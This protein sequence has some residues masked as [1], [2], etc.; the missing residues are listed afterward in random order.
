LAGPTTLTFSVRL[1]FD[2]LFVPPLEDNILITTSLSNLNLSALFNLELNAEQLFIVPFGSLSLN[3][4]T[5]LACAL[6]AV[7][8]LSLSDTYLNFNDLYFTATCDGPCTSP[9]LQ[10]I[11]GFVYSSQPFASLGAIADYIPGIIVAI[12]DFIKTPTVQQILYG[13]ATTSDTCGVSFDLAPLVAVIN[14]PPPPDFRL[15]VL[16]AL[17]ILGIVAGFVALLPLAIPRHY[18]LKTKLLAMH[19]RQANEEP[20][21][22]PQ[23]VARY[24]AK[25]E[26]EALP[27]MFHPEVSVFTKLFVPMAAVVNIAFLGLSLLFYEAFSIS[28]FVVLFG[29]YTQLIYLVPLTIGT[30]ID[31]L[32]NSG[33]GY[34]GI[35]L[36]LLSGLWPV[37]KNCL[38]VFLLLAPKWIL[39]PEQRRQILNILD[40]F[41]KFSFVEALFIII[42]GAGLR[43]QIITS[44]IPILQGI[45]IP[46]D[47]LI[48]NVTCTIQ[49]GMV[50]LCVAGMSTLL[51]NHLLV[52]EHERAAFA[53][54]RLFKQIDGEEDLVLTPLSEVTFRSSDY[55]FSTIYNPVH[56]HDYQPEMALA[57]SIGPSGKPEPVADIKTAAFDGRPHH[58]STGLHDHFDPKVQNMVI[59]IIPLTNLFLLVGQIAPLFSILY[60]GVLGL[61]IGLVIEN[62]QIRTFSLMAMGSEI[63]DLSDG[64]ALT[65]F[66][67]MF[68]QILFYVSIIIAPHV[69]L[70]LHLLLWMK[71]YKLATAKKIY[72]YAKCAGYW[73]SMEVFLVAVIGIILE[74]DPIVSFLTDGVVGG[75]CSAAQPYLTDILGSFNGVCLRTTAEAQFGFY[76][77]FAGMLAQLGMGAVMIRANGLVIRDREDLLERQPHRMW[78]WM[79]YLILRYMFAFG[80]EHH[81]PYLNPKSTMND[82]MI[83][84]LANWLDD[85]KKTT[86]DIA[87]QAREG[88]TVSCSLASCCCC[89]SGLD[90]VGLSDPIGGKPSSK[91]NAPPSVN[92]HRHIESG[93]SK[94]NAPP[95]VALSK[96]TANPRVESSTPSVVSRPSTNAPMRPPPPKSLTVPK[97]G[98]YLSGP[99]GLSRPAQKL[100]SQ[101]ESQP[102]SVVDE[103][104]SEA[105]NPIFKREKTFSVDV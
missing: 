42:V 96:A 28:T 77:A 10:G 8:D 65:N 67:L 39:L 63:A 62:G 94:W 78:T 45:S 81:R 95:S 46:D 18:N 33:A 66:K 27:L 40:I 52:W 70:G 43:F 48:I 44:Q 80:G 64:T 34:L 93:A 101:P 72:F 58:A 19:L 83:M 37:L 61:L 21:A 47:L 7:Q 92:N 105:V 53:D 86:R 102:G 41:G 24:M 23:S 73:A 85:P 91:W 1:G 38:F 9:M 89:F 15:S 75:R 97:S 25:M 87:N 30:L 74:I 14:A 68:F 22:T 11:N 56:P 57:H 2:K 90:S 54:R 32:W 88:M 17:A 36:V 31:T 84:M 76:I 55:V 5:Q 13:G 104:G 29:S 59:F 79:E 4:L 35:G 103:Q 99:P 3:N 49:G 82:K 51:L 69:Q 60:N 50:I 26:R 71:P 16:L 20:N 12:T 98:S 6:T 100:G